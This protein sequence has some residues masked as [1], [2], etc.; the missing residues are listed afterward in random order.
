VA[1]AAMADL[2]E[3]RIIGRASGAGTGVP[4]ALT[5]AQALAVLGIETYDSGQQS[6]PSQGATLQL[7]HGLTD[8]D[9]VHVE[10]SLE[11]TT[12]DN[13]WAVGD[14]VRIPDISFDGTSGQG[15][16]VSHNDT[17]VE[18]VRGVGATALYIKSTGQQFTFTD[19]SWRV[20]VH[21]VRYP[22]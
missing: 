3:A 16:A 5:G 10:A 22:S 1:L 13:D 6:V 4:T 8:S 11:C 19:S 18:I 15:F 12:T 17:Y 20:V 7:T 9:H 14:K 2:A 21:A